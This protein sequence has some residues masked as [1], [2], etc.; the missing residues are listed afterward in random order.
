LDKPSQAY[1]PR[2]HKGEQAGFPR[3]Q[4]RNRFHSFTL[5][6]YGK[7]EYGNQEYGKKEYGKKE[8]G[9]GARLDTGYLVLSKIGRIAVHGSRSSQGPPKRVTISREADGCYG[10]ISCAD[11]LVPPV[12]PSGQE[13]GIDLGIEAF[14]T[15][16]EG[17]RILPPGYYR[18]AQR[19]LAQCHRRSA[20]RKRGSHRRP[21]A[22]HLLAKA[23]QTGRRQRADFHHQTALALVH[24]TAVIDQEDVQ[25][26]TR[27]QDQGSGPPARHV[28]PS[29]SKSIQVEPSRA[30]SSQVDPR[31]GLGGVPGHPCLHGSLCR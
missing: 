8:Y 12:P 25:V 23:H 30:K 15:R 29:R 31:R 17:A 24:T 20:K 19:S 2:V 27:V 9:N 1:F 22:V 13:T 10:A 3:F 6:E 7:K 18:R 14:A 28:D 16:R 4:G 11:V 21:K 5:K 26:R